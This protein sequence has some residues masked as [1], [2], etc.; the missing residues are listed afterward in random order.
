MWGM[1]AEANC[2]NCGAKDF[3]DKKGYECRHCGYK[4]V[5]SKELPECKLVFCD[6]CGC[7]L[8]DNCSVHGAIYCKPVELHLHHETG[9]PDKEI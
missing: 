2:H 6:V 7:T 8:I 9:T 4:I 5:E 3:S 1:K